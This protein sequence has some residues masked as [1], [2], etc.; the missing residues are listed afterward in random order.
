MKALLNV[1]IRFHFVILF[2]ILEIISVR[3]VI[4]EDLEKKNA[5]FSSANSISGFFHKKLDTW[6]AYFTLAHENEI[7]RNE[8]LQLKNLLDENQQ[9]KPSVN[10]KS[11]T[12]KTDSI[13]YTYIFTKVINNSIYKKQNYI[14]L[15]K[16]LN[17]GIKKDFGVISPKGIVGV[18]VAVSKNYSLVVSILNDRIGISAKIKKNNQFG[19]VQWNKNDYRIASLTEIPNHINISKGDTIVSSGFSSIFPPDINIGTI[20]KFNIN[21]SN[22]FYEIDIK[23]ST[24]FKSLYYVYVIDNSMR[25]EQLFLENTVSDEY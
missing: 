22:N 7:L 18:V 12:S 9:K 16:G 4:I 10:V 14:T 24:D 21:K 6:F 17:Q 5:V 19:S 11:D 1:I 8:N 23:L 20:N 2:I 3:M 15:D 13:K 25:K